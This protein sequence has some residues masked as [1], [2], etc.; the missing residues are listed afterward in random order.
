MSQHLSSV[1]LDRICA[2]LQI[3]P[4]VARRFV[5]DYLGLLDPRLAR[6]DAVLDADGRSPAVSTD[7]TNGTVSTVSTGRDAEDA[8]VALLGLESSSSMLGAFPVALAARR[9]RIELQ[10]GRS[11][12]IGAYR[13][14]LARAVQQVRTQLGD[15]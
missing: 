14:E 8:T 2:E 13:R 6:I 15:V 9:L 5:R 1:R 10:T 7:S 12:R 3:R 4:E 11:P